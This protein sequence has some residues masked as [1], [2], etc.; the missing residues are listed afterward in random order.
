MK[1]RMDSSIKCTLTT[2]DAEDMC[3]WTQDL[4]GKYSDGSMVLQGNE[5]TLRKFFAAF[6]DVLPPVPPLCRLSIAF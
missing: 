1:F 6:G 3:D 2:E 5:S 4:C